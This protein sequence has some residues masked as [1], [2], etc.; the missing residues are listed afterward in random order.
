MEKPCW[1]WV[2]T[3]FSARECA[4]RVSLSVSRRA[5]SQNMWTGQEEKGVSMGRSCLEGELITT[6][7]CSYTCGSVGEERD[8]LVDWK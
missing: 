8:Q 2:C 7:M 6:V 5:K 1:P 3:L 4:R